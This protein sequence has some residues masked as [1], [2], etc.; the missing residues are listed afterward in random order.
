MERLHLVRPT[1]PTARLI[2]R[3]WR[4]D[5]MA[6]FSAM[7][8]NPLVMQYPTRLPDRSAIERWVGNVRAHLVACRSTVPRK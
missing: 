2:L 4:G 7:S 5:D 6:P 1:L 3:E 8:T